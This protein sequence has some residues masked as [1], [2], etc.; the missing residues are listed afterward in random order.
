MTSPLLSL[1]LFSCLLIKSM[2]FAAKKNSYREKDEN[3]GNELDRD[4]NGINSSNI[5]TKIKIKKPTNLRQQHSSS[6]STPFL[7]CQTATSLPPQYSG[8]AAVVAHHSSSGTTTAGEPIT[9]MGA[10]TNLWLVLS[11]GNF[12]GFP[13]D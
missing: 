3:L 2:V 7:P 13:I 10:F 8:S 6:G 5:Y 12:Y 9:T 4:L 1:V 11:D